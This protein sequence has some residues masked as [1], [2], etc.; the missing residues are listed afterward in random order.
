MWTCIHAHSVCVHVFTGG[1]RGVLCL[2]E[3]DILQGQTGSDLLLKPVERLTGGGSHS[4][5]RVAV[6]N[7]NSILPKWFSFKKIFLLM[8]SLVSY[9]FLWTFIPQP[10]LH[11]EIRW[12]DTKGP[13]STDP[14]T[15]QDTSNSRESATVNS[16]QQS[17]SSA[18]QEGPTTSSR[19]QWVAR[20]IDLFILTPNFLL[21]VFLKW[22]AGLNFYIKSEWWRTLSCLSM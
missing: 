19:V 16:A 8:Y 18:H 3:H 10:P 15:D 5:S 20:T 1:S 17:A 9:N 12:W 22:A 21:F 13:N 6:N 2:S 11:Q 14:T 4:G 7:V